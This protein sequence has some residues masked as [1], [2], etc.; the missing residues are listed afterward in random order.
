[1]NSKPWAD[2]LGKLILRLTLGGLML[3]H[4]VAK[5]TGGVGGIAGM[6]ES[7]G[8]PSALAYGVYVGEVLAP[9]LLIV[10]LFTRVSAL[11]LAFNMVVAV[12]L[13]HPGQVLELGEHGG[14]AIEL[15]VLYLAPAVALA[16]LGPGAWSVD[17]ARRRHAAG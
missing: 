4:G 14:W 6:L 11:V 8:L 9:L 3:L 5:L 10:G 7:K 17:A 15:Q 2:D 1:M 16:L 12:A 13:A